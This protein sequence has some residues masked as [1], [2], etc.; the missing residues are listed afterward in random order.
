MKITPPERAGRRAPA[1]HFT[2]E[3]WMDPLHDA[4]EPARANALLVTFLPGGRTNWHT[5]PYGQV[6]YVVSGVGRAQSRGKPVQVI[7]PGDVIWFE[8]GEEHWHG[9]APDTAMVHIAFQEAVGGSPVTW[10]EEVSE[11][12]YRAAPTD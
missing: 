11:D 9:A 8:P 2:G 5:H 10:L 6:L 12:D 3:V 1:D 4:P 7:R